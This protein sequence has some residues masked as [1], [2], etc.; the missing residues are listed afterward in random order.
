MKI[1][2]ITVFCNEKFRL[3]NWKYYFSEYKDDI[4]MHVIVNNGNKEDTK[5]LHEIFPDSIILESEGSNLVRA[6]NIGTKYILKDKSID[7]IMQITNDI[8]FKKGGI[9]ELYKLL[10]SDKN[11]AVSG[12]VLLEKD[13]NRVEVFGIDVKN[14][15]L[16][17]GHQ[18]FPYRGGKSKI[19]LIL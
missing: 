2:C 9:A 18:F 10:Y 12:P 19:L 3:D 11:I 6:Y 7:A 15:D 17:R 8:K 4:S 13:S 1:A 5:I 14:N 16:I